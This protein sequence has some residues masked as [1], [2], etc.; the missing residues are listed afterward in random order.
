MKVAQLICHG[1][2]CTTLVIKDSSIRACTIL[3]IEDNSTRESNIPISHASKHV[4]SL[5]L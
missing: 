5:V 4:T 1:S 3:V 2:K